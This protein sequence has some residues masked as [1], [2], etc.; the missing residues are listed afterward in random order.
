MEAL[1]HLGL[2]L[3]LALQTFSPAL[4][5]PMKFFTY[6]GRI[7]FYLILIPFVYWTIDRRLGMRMLLIL[8]LVDIVGTAF[9]LFFHQPRPYWI[10]GVQPLTEEASYGIPSTHASDSIAVLG[11]LAYRVK[12]TWLWILTVLVLFFIGLSRSYLGAHFPHDVLFGWLIGGLI[13]WGFIRSEE[14]VAAWARSK[15]PGMQIGMGFTI[16][17]AIILSGVLLRSLISG[18][19]DPASWSSYAAEARALRPFF[20]LSGALFGSI[21][22]YALMREYARFQTSGAWGRRILRYL[23]GMI[24]VVLIYFGLDILFG[25]IASDET[26]P[27]YVLRYIRYATATFWMTFVAPYLFLKL[28]LADTEAQ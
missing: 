11:Y 19:A 13:L 3:I 2:S 4:D 14:S 1:Q 9:K 28:R 18:T 24:G 10:G 25:L 21:S 23:L 8:I 27:G 20:T 15:T 26:I 16:S 17:V 7:E 5:A 22:G 12:R 6:L